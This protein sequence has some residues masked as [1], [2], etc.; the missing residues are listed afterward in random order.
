MT[1][2]NPIVRVERERHPKVFV[3]A[4]VPE[5]AIRLFEPV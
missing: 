1:R 2:G 3:F 5:E 4:G